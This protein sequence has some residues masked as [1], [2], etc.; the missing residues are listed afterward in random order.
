MTA[1]VLA[2]F[3]SQVPPAAAEPPEVGVFAQWVQRH[4]LT[5]HFAGNAA[6]VHQRERAFRLQDDTF[7]DAFTLVPEARELAVSAT[8]AFRTGT[9]LQSTGLVSVGAGVG[10]TLVATLIPSL[11]LP[12]LVVALV[13]SGAALVLT[14]IA[15][16]FL[17]NAQSKFLSSV[18]TYNRGLLDLR[19][20]AQPQTSSAD[21]SGGLTLTL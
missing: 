7:A 9:A 19:P 4:L 8:A 3:V 5:L 17:L 11:L 1:L 6:E 18:A 21:G 20:P 12:L 2:L 13:M 16:P 10:L 15:L 14:V